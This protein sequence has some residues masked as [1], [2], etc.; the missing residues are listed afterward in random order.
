ML[1]FEDAAHHLLSIVRQVPRGM[2]P[3]P[4]LLPVSM[5]PG[6]EAT[7]ELHWVSGDVYDGH[8]CVSPTTA[9]VQVGADTYRQPFSNRF[10]SAAN[11]PATF[12]QTWLKADAVVTTSDGRPAVAK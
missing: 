1:H 11:A 3:G 4:V 10:C 9:V 5:A 2:H 7:A 6:A 12:T 8:N